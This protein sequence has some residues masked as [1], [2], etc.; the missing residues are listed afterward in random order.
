[1]NLL[2]CY[3]SAVSAKKLVDSPIQREVIKHFQC[4]LDALNESGF[5][6]FRRHKVMK[7]IYLYGP[8]GGGKTLLMDMFYQQLPE[9]RKLRIHF[10][11]FMQQVDARLR[12]LQGKKNPLELIAVEWSRKVRVLCLDE[13]MVHD[14]A[15]AMILAELLQF[16]LSRRVIL[17]ATSN[18][19]PDDLYLNGLQRARF[20]P[21][22]DL[23]KRHCEI[24]T[25]ADNR[26]YRLGRVP[27][28]QAYLYPLNGETQHVMQKQFQS[29]SMSLLDA[30]A[31]YVQQRNIPCVVLS[32]RAVWF[33]FDVICHIPRSQLDYLEIATRFS[34]VFISEVPQFTEEQAVPALLWAHLV[35][36]FYDKRIRLIVSAAVA[37]EQLYLAE[38][39][40]QQFA[41]TLSRLYEMQSIDYLQRTVYE[42]NN[43]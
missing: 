1:M 6:W 35:D 29:V 11:E 21:A 22:I 10:H 18:A 15:D 36:V 5:L 42:S 2:E 31:L 32:E 9:K 33:R 24:L 38:P 14:I 19:R 37:L 3:Q 27:L 12:K 20:L 39:L 30:K 16:L 26:D 23:L 25:L 43:A 7:G 4:L 34:T 8:V 41:R 28:L 40:R 17:V 13:F